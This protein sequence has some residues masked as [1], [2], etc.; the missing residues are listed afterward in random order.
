M[1]QFTLETWFR[2][3]GTG[4]TANT[5]T[6]GFYGIPLV[7]KGVGEAE[8]SN[9]DM[10]YF[11]GI[12]GSDNVLGADFEEGATGA[13]PGL[14]HPVYGTTAIPADSTWHHAAA[15][16]DGQV[17]RLYLD[18]NLE[19]SLDLGSAI[20]PRAD[21]IQHAG[22][23]VAL[24]STGIASGHFDGALDEVRIWSVVRTQAQIRAAINSQITGSQTNLVGRWALEEG[25]GSTVSSTAG[26]TIDGTITGSG[27]N[28]ISVGAPFN[29]NFPPDVTNPGNQ[30]NSEGDV[31]SL[32]IV[33]SDL[34]GDTLTYSATSLPE[35]LNIDLSTGLIAGT[36]GSH[37]AANSP[38]SAVVTVND[39]EGGSTQIS[40]IWTVTQPASGLCD[41]D[42]TLVGCWPMEEGSGTVVIDATSFGNDGNITGSP[43]WVTGK[44]GSY[45][46][47]LSGTGQYAVVPDSNS[48]NIGTNNITLSAW[49][50]PTKTATQ[51][52]IKKAIGT[53]AP[54]GYEL[55]LSAGGKVFVRFNGGTT[56]TTRVDS[57]SSYP[58]DGNTWIHV[59]ATFD[60]SIIKVYIN[61]VLDNS[62][63]I[64]FTIAPNSTN[65]GIGAQADGVSPFQGLIDD[66][67]YN[68]A[69]SLTDIEV[70]A[71]LRNLLNASKS[72]TGSGAVTSDPAGIDCGTTCSYAFVKNTLV[73]LTAAASP[74]L[75]LHRLERPRLPRYGNL[76]GD[77]RH[78]QERDG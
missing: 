17:W 70:L 71:G 4:T 77:D 2:R 24:D 41:N 29:I 34:D 15:T 72:G 43:T 19:Q 73:T 9:V 62:K 12:R 10:N 35:G 42:P 56:A 20:P 66:A 30:T 28:W 65:L 78:R 48:L 59:A 21:S 51:Y 53:T 37:A 22:L 8:N 23:A 26:T 14:N 74:R 31:V 16:Y 40:L 55:S 76:R 44:V 57:L 64:S 11:F 61:G 46:L 27:W 63:S 36:I 58:T 68:R 25:T 47:S 32:Q 52:I 50:K 5:G 33:A 60:G 54:N 1:P 69:L 49:V 75:D 6:G 45:A 3:D 7:A 67:P 13:S 38:Y 39:G 18:G